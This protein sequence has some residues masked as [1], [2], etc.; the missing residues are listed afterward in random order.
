MAA[1]R[2]LPGTP[3]PRFVDAAAPLLSDPVRAVRI[4]AARALAGTDLLALTPEQQTALVKATAEL[5]AAEMVDADRPEAHLNLGLLDLRRRELSGAEAEYRSALR[6]D[7]NFVP[8]LVNLADLDR[9]RGM[10][11][12]GAEFLKKA[13]AIEPDNADVRYALGLYLVRKHDYPG[14]LDLLRRAHELM[15]DNPLYAYVYAVALNSSGAAKEALALLEEA[16]QQHPADRNILTALVSIARDNGDFAAALRH[17]RELAVI[18][19]E[20]RGAA[21]AGRGPRTE[22]ASVG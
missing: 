22:S 8:A 7:P 2:A 20:K 4:E 15:P 14:A 17:A 11:D 18:E 19:P 13:M 1:P 16:H 9:A 10:D 21:C 5:V 3:P 6:L 12:E